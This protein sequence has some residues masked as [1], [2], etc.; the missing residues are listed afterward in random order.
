MKE[1]K[2]KILYHKFNDWHESD[3]GKEI[4]IM[5]NLLENYLDKNPDYYPLSTDMEITSDGSGYIKWLLLT[6][7]FEKHE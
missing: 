3:V 2:I 7:I 5:N 1:R 4:E 6:V